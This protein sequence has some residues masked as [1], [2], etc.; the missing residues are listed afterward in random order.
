MF[1]FSVRE[2]FAYAIWFT[3]KDAVVRMYEEHPVSS[4]TIS[5]DELIKLHILAVIEFV[6]SGFKDVSTDIRLE[7]YKSKIR[8]IESLTTPF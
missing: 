4:L 1:D 7:T 2:M 8:F 3:F 5:V 6:T